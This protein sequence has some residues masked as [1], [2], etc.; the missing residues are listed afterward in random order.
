MILIFP[1]LQ[2]IEG[3]TNYFVYYCLSSIW[4]IVRAH[5]VLFPLYTVIIY[6]F[7]IKAP[8][9]LSLSCPFPSGPLA[10]QRFSS[11]WSQHLRGRNWLVNGGHFWLVV[12][13]MAFINWNPNSWDDDP[14]WRTKI[15]FGGVVETTNQI[16]SEYSPSNFDINVWPVSF[17]STDCSII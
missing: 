17:A 1:S 12:W 9:K 16:Y 8:P 2:Y 15:F 10:S 13:N 5:V 3:K 6:P 14:I 4:L 11:C 7:D